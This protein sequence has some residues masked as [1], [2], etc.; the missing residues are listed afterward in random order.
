MRNPKIVDDPPIDPRIKTFLG[1]LEMPAAKDAASREEILAEADSDDAKAALATIKVFMDMCDNEDVAPSAG[2]TISTREF[3]SEP[4]G[5]TIKVQLIQPDSAEP[6]PCVYYIHGGG[7]Q[8]MSCFDGNY[9]A[10][11]KII[12]AQ[13]IAVA[14]VDFRNSFTPSSAPELGP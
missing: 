5:N 10:W 7:M 14:M 3:T 8:M 1:A 2:L 4:D 12:S 11:A 13:G 6:L 9:R